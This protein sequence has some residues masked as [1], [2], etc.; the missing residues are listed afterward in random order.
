MIDITGRELKVVLL[1]RGAHELKKRYIFDDIMN[2]L[3]DDNHK[4][5]CLYGLRRTG[6]TIL[7]AQSIMELDKYDDSLYALCEENDTVGELKKAYQ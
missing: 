6:K 3:N 1:G 2:Y 7:M 5:M 4:V